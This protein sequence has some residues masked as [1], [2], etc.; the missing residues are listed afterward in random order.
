MNLPLNIDL[1]DKV[2]VVT[3]A[4]GI[5]C[6]LF[7]KAVAK[8]GAKVALLDLNLEAAQAYADEMTSERIIAKAYNANVLVKANLEAGQ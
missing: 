7:A 6:S 4:G 1:K 3:G 2:V 5:L 8:C